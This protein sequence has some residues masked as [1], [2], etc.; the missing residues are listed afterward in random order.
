MLHATVLATVRSSIGLM[1]CRAWMLQLLALM[2]FVTCRLKDKSWS[3]VTSRLFSCT[4]YAIWEPATQTPEPLAN[5]M[6]LAGRAT[7]RTLDFS[8]FSSMLFFVN[9]S[10]TARV[11]SSSALMSD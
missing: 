2:M 1:C 11:H 5:F 4:E 8:G 7:N 9:Q 3:R 6:A 10:L